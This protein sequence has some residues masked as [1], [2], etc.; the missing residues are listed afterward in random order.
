MKIDFT[1]EDNGT[2]EG[3]EEE[4]AHVYSQGISFM[5][6]KGLYNMSD[7]E[8]ISAF[9]TYAELHLKVDVPKDDKEDEWAYWTPGD[10]K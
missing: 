10:V 6:L 9:K 1:D 7:S 4:M 5:M 3:T 2:L 8:A